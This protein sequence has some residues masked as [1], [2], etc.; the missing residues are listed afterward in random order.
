MK[1]LFKRAIFISI[2]LLLILT[3]PYGH[4]PGETGISEHS[5]NAISI[6]CP[7]PYNA[8]IGVFSLLLERA[9]AYHQAYINERLSESLSN[10]R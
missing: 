9:I 3:G 8:K 4:K 6:S 7:K 5:D 2:I 10:K 1:T